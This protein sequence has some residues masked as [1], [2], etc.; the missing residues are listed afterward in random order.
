MKNNFVHTRRIEITRKRENDD[1]HKDESTLICKYSFLRSFGEI[2]DILFAFKNINILDCTNN[3]LVDFDIDIVLARNIGKLNISCN[4]ITSFRTFEKCEKLKKLSCGDNLIVSF[5]GIETLNNLEKLNCRRNKISDTFA[6]LE[7]LDRLTKLDCSNNNICGSFLP[8]KNLKNLQ[9]LDCSNNNICGSFLPLKNL[10]NLQELFCCHNNITSKNFYGLQ[11]LTKLKE[12]YCENNQIEGSFVCLR[13]LKYLRIVLCGGNRI[14]S[15][16]GLSP[17]TDSNYF[18]F[19]SNP[20]LLRST[21][22]DMKI[23]ELSG[24][25]KFRILAKLTGNSFFSWFSGDKN[26]LNKLYDYF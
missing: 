13:D 10:Q 15:I 3:E 6:G 12:I 8:L 18:L 21:C 17:R 1:N 22:Y 2:A 14:N 19:A 4:K 9:E 16:K 26:N 5:D 11:F 25:S 23:S 24:T 20:F 7:G